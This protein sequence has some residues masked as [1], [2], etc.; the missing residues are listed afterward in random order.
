MLDPREMASAKNCPYSK[1]EDCEETMEIGILV[2][3]DEGASFLASHHSVLH[4]V[5]PLSHDHMKSD[6]PET[7]GTLV[8]VSSRKGTKRGT[9][10][11]EWKGGNEHPNPEFCTQSF[12]AMDMDNQKKPKK[13]IPSLMPLHELIGYEADL[14]VVPSSVIPPSFGLMGD[15]ESPSE[16]IPIHLRLG[17]GSDFAHCLR[18]PMS[19]F[20]LSEGH[21]TMMAPSVLASAAGGSKDMSANFE[22]EDGWL[23]RKLSHDGLVDT[24][25][26]TIKTLSPRELAKTQKSLKGLINLHQLQQNSTRHHLANMEVPSARL[27]P[28]VCDVEFVEQFG[29]QPAFQALRV[30]VHPSN[31]MGGLDIIGAIDPVA[32]GLQAPV[33]KCPTPWMALGLSRSEMKI[34]YTQSS[35]DLLS[36]MHA[37]I[38]APIQ[39]Q[40]DPVEPTWP[41]AV[42]SHMSQP[43]GPV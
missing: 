34:G 42:D 6:A 3:E 31:E 28:P 10:L 36:G 33:P 7:S 12:S 9:D 1:S 29:L 8:G 27:N 16:R 41:R 39:M 2:D 4:I 15:P 38:F 21:K 32:M 14:E 40:V 24:S 43:R 17:L 18:K 25:S 22:D 5:S 26:E 35:A 20:C 11:L 13:D 23:S 30:Q 19:P 37:M